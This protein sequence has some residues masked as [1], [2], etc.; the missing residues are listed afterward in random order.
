MDIPRMPLLRHE[1]VMQALN[2]PN[3]NEWQI[4][5]V[6]DRLLE[7]ERIRRAVEEALAPVLRDE[8]DRVF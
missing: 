7:Q 1:R 2:P 6:H 8:E 4:R 3:L 5:W